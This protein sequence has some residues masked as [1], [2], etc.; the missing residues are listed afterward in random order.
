MY[1]AVLISNWEASL[2]KSVA[3]QRSV[4]ICA[5]VF[6]HIYVC[7]YEC[8]CVPGLFPC[9]LHNQVAGLISKAADREGALLK[10]IKCYLLWKADNT[11]KIAALLNK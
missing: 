6:V 5:Q 8:V 10:S 3:L 2:V 4:G 1:A 7:V 9:Q 11:S